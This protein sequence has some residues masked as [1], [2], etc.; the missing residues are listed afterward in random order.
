MDPKGKNQFQIEK[1]PWIEYTVLAAIIVL[2]VIL[3]FYKL[4]EWSLWEDEVFSIGFAEDGF[5]FSIWRQSLAVNLIHLATASLGASAWSA[6]LVPA[7]IGILSIPLLYFPV[8]SLFNPQTSLFAMLLLAVS[9]WHLYWSQNARFY[10]LLFLFFNLGLLLFFIGL[11]KDRLIWYIGSLV[12]IGMAAR[13]SLVALFA[14][15]ILLL[16]LVLVW[17]LPMDKPVGLKSRN[18]FIFLGTG[19]LGG[20]I[21][22]GPY[23]R[24]LS[25]WLKAFGRINNNPF[26][27]L[28]GS[29]YYIGLPLACIAAL[30]GMHFLLKRTERPRLQRVSLF[31]GIAG[32]IP[33]LAVMAVSLFHYTANRYIFV[34]LLAWIILGALTAIEIFSLLPKRHMLIASGVLVLLL[35]SPLSEDF[36]YFRYQNGNRADWIASTTYIRENMEPGDLVVSATK[37]VADF[38]L[39]GNSIPLKYWDPTNSPD[40]GTVWL[41]E[42]LT[43]KELAPELYIWLREQAELVAVYDVNAQARTFTMRVYRY[44]P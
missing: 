15:P 43:V 33:L 17:L 21:I 26:W 22:A 38:Y 30:G 2:A 35:I 25:D 6:R 10:S 18:L 7:T 40:S 42:D 44:E 12:F 28:A 37:S 39:G 36:L 31:F 20:L 32:A 4:G 1:H 29:I 16:Y 27:I 19:L 9:P 13:E 23:L 11:E 34:S 41:I 8:R 3:R 14:G 5:N 24:N